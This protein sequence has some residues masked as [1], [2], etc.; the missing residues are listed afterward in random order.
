MRSENHSDRNIPMLNANGGEMGACKPSFRFE[1]IP[2][3]LGM[4]ISAQGDVCVFH[5]YHGDSNIRSTYR[6][7]HRPAA[8]LMCSSCL[9]SFVIPSISLH[10][11][12]PCRQLAET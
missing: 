2:V 3:R 4:L 9:L 7:A 11:R 5:I 8:L 6:H 10:V 1:F 12:K